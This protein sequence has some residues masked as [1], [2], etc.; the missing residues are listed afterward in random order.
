MLAAELLEI[1][2]VTASVSV[3]SRAATVAVRRAAPTSA[4]S[5]KLSPGPRTAIVTVSPSGEMIRITTR[6]FS[7]R[8]NES[9]G[10]SR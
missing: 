7:I 1:V 8:C 5:P 6:P 3:R 9:A 4:I 2:L 10:S